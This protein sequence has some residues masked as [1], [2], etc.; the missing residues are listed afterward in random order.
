MTVTDS[1]FSYTKVDSSS[2]T[3]AS[4]LANPLKLLI[5]DDNHSDRMILQTIVKRQGHDVVTAVDGIDAIE[6]F[7]EEGPDIILLDAL[8]PRMDG[9]EAAREIKRLSGEDLIPI[10]FLTSLSD[11]E[12][13]ANCLEAGGD[14]F[15]SKPYNPI[16]LQAKINAFNRMRVMHQTLQ[17]QR[18][19]ISDNNE[20][21]LREQEVAK[22]VFDNVA[23]AGCLGAHNI[24]HLLSPL[25]VFN[26]DVL[27]ACQ[28]PSGGMHVLLGDFTGHGL[29]AAIGAM[30]LAEIFYG[31]T[32]KGYALADIVREINLK[33][34]AIL[35]VGFFCCASMVDID[36]DE[37]SVEVWSGGLPDGYLLQNGQLVTVKSRH[38]PLG[39]KDNDSFDATTDRYEMSD[40]DRI[41]LWSDGIIEASNA[42]KGFYGEERLR[43][44]VSRYI[45]SADLFYK[46]QQDVLEFAGDCGPGDDLTMAEI[47]MMPKEDLGIP[48]SE[49]FSTGARGL[50][51]WEM[52]YRLSDDSLAR[53]DPVPLLLRI[54][55]EVPGMR[56]FN[57]DIFT[58]ISELYSNALDHGVLRLD[59][60][61]K[62][63]SEGFAEYYRQ[64]GVRS[65]HL[66]GH[67]VII[68][69]QHESNHQKGV[70][71]VRVEDSGSGFDCEYLSEIQSSAHKYSGRGVTLLKSLCRK[72]QYYPPGNIVEV[73]YEWPT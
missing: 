26:G 64:R 15:L 52:T 67:Y 37:K 56:G 65:Q 71:T 46:I 7:S 20:H 61:L 2:T 32:T 29:P 18:D 73:E 10:I 35:P 72:V 54:V 28:K 66:E 9:F 4:A 49:S 41:Y 55:M 57:G 25:S 12:S 33:L 19:Q 50:G 24:R 31:M 6:K 17:H 16:I 47:T 39:I 3:P 60:K 30:P 14:D 38:L 5:A 1:G 21:L 22:K 11:A 62:S 48:E 63:S 45:D 68:H 59:S 58:I 8:M 69:L 40:G 13:L 51:N 43:T 23:H 36:F 34:K 53:Y 27:L 70:L 42:Q 44:L